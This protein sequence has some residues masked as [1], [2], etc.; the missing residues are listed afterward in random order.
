VRGFFLFAA[1]LVL[2]VSMMQV[3]SA[4][5]GKASGMRLNHVGLNAKD[6]DETLN[7][8]TK[9]M[10]FHEAFALRDKDGK[11][12]LA[13]VQ[14]S[15]ET[16]LEIIPAGPDRPAGLTHFGIEAPNVNS[17]AARLRGEGVKIEDAKPSRTNSLLTSTI[18]PNGVRFELAALPPEA[19]ARKAMES[20][21]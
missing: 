16:F 9:T 19:L 18:D 7:F 1:G 14:I 3:V 4:Q 12:T 2:G 11:P 13:Y 15:R 10:G 21:K 6:M 5:E 20:W 8:Y 17:D